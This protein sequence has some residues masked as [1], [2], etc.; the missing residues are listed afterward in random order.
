MPP[1]SGTPGSPILHSTPAS[2]G[3]DTPHLE[4]HFESSVT[5]RDIVIGLSDGLTVPFALAA[6]LSGAVNSSRIV[7]LAG[8]AEIAAGSIAMGLGGYLAARGDA[9][10]Y[11][12]EK[13]REER[14]VVERMPDEEEEIYE[15]FEQYSV[16]RANAAPVLEALKQNPAAWVNFMMRFELGLEEPAPNRAHRSALTIALSYV[17]G[18]F[19]PLLPYMLVNSNRL[20][21]QL[22]IAITLLALAL[23]G[24]LKGKMVGTGWLRSAIQTVVIGGTA[25]AAAYGLALLLN[26]HA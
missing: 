14:E 7:V 24:A 21:L 16:P 25:A 18:G 11:A 17:A 10:H 3:G 15:I 23:F 6:G 8:L 20:A 4:G 1:S 26:E 2:S 22:S 5:V 12:S 9:E 13:K 19:V